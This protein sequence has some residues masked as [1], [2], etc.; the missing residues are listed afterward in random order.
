MKVSVFFGVDRSAKNGH[1]FSA[2]SD[3][4]KW[5]ST[6]IKKRFRDQVEEGVREL[7]S[8]LS[9]S[10]SVHMMHK[11]EAQRIFLTLLTDSVQHMLKLH[12]MMEAQFFRY[13]SV[14]GTGCD[15]GN[16][17]LASRFA[18]AVFAG[19]WRARVIGADA[20]KETGHTRCA[21][22]LWASLQTHRVFQGYI[23]LGFI[24]H[25]E[26]SSVVVDHLIQTRVPMINYSHSR[27]PPCAPARTHG[28]IQAPREPPN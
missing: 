15:D 22:Y 28:R 20:F 5:E 8:S 14:L 24:A 21:K 12:R 23:E 11:V 16:W 3:F 26:V 6:G 27:N 17:I 18:E 9:R 13:R 25:P 2:I 1:P 7:E 19:T 10:M 4:S